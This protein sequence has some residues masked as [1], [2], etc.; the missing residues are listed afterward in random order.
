MIKQ[1]ICAVIFFGSRA[2]ENES[3]SAVSYYYY[4]HFYCCVNHHTYCE[5]LM[6]LIVFIN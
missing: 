5:G 6:K 1:W 3:V 2:S 4:C